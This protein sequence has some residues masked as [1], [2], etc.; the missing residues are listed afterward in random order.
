MKN[1]FINY[2]NGKT[3]ILVTHA[4]QYVAFADRIFYMKDGEINWMGNYE[5]IKN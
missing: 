1:C 2:L 3:R 5:E 4:L